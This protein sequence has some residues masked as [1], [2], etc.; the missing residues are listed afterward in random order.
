MACI[1]T[2]VVLKIENDGHV[3]D[4]TTI[5][6]DLH[7]V[8]NCCILYHPHDQVPHRVT[9]GKLDMDFGRNLFQRESRPFDILVIP[10]ARVTMRKGSMHEWDLSLFQG[11]GGIIDETPGE[12]G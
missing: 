5:Y 4:G 10:A 9:H 3:P 8:G 11:A 7:L 2:G 1:K 12:L 6:G